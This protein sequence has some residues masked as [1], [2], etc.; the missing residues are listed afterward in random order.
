M[1]G[2][3]RGNRGVAVVQD[4][5][6]PDCPECGGWMKSDGKDWNCTSCDKHL[7]KDSRRGSKS[8]KKKDDFFNTWGF[9][10]AAASAYAADC[11]QAERIIVTS[12]QNNTE[13]EVAFLQSLKVCAEHYGARLVVVPTQLQTF[14]L[15]DKDKP[16]KEWHPSVA[17]YLVKGD[18]EIGN[19]TIRSDVRIKPTTINPLAGKHGHC[20]SRWVIF[21]H[22]QH[23][24]EPVASPAD[25]LPKRM[26][27]TGSVT[28]P[29]YTISDAGEKAKFHHVAGALL[30]ENMGEHCFIRHLNAD[31]KGAFYD[32]DKRFTP[33]GVTNGHRLAVL[34]PGDEHVK[35]NACANET[36]LNK[37]SI[38]NTLRPE[39]IVRHDVLDG[40]AG[41]HHHEKDD[42]LGFRKFHKGDCD[43][44]AELE[45]CVEF[46]NKT[47]PKWAKTLIVPSNHHDHL[48]QWLSRVDPKKDPL[49]A[50]L[51]HDM[52][53]MQYENALTDDQKSAF[54]LYCEGKLKC[55]H[56]FLDRNKQHII[57]GIDHAQ[58]GD[59]GSNGSR[60]SAKGLAKSTHKMT[61][62]HSH[63]AR[64]FQGVAQA[65]TSTGRLEYERGLSDHSMTHVIQYKNGKRAFIDIISGLWRKA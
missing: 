12:A 25:H 55:K 65:A 29:N 15:F 46:I 6:R 14:G 39:F 57:G 36:Y 58:H 50:L 42:V 28:K 33:Q 13:P 43:Y 61:I 31:K 51:I 41:S 2:S 63:G 3:G 37:D 10:T 54:Q 64:L 62:G 16:E 20:G 5:T 11:H 56:E 40:Y 34:T 47:T 32:L 17:P 21:G 44:R 9:N 7:R 23:M 22:P 38:C 26:Y 49:N 27:T 19:V 18:I 8:R 4:E 48:D 30:I 53:K 1:P 52:K 45:Q 24:M 60:G 35:F 59:V